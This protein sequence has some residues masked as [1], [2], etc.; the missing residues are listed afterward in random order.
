[1]LAG[2]VK[3]DHARINSK[4]EGLK[5]VL[6]DYLGVYQ[7]FFLSQECVLLVANLS[8]HCGHKK[9]QS[10]YQDKLKSHQY[11]VLKQPYI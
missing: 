3:N 1:M 11:L 2:F 6:S 5:T 10:K 9:S 4:P 8:S 7:E